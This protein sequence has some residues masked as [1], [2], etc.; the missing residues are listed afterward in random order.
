MVIEGIVDSLDGVADAL[1]PA[2][3]QNQKTGKFELQVKGYTTA[4]KVTE[5]RDNNVDLSK[6]IAKYETEMAEYRALGEDPKALTEEV[7]N[8]RKLGQQLENQE[9]VDKKGFEG[10]LAQ[11]VEQM[12]QD[13]EGKVAAL[14]S[15]LETLKGERDSAVAENKRIV[16]SGDITRAALAEGVLPE[17]IPDLLLRADHSGWTRNEKGDV[18]L[19][20]KKSN[21]IVYGANGADPLTPEEWVIGLKQNARH[22]FNR[23]SGAGGLGSDH[24][25]GAPNPWAKDTWDDTAQALAYRADPVRAEAM[26][27]AAGS[28]VGAL[29]P[30]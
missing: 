8:L 20:D 6:R 13:F 30:A 21:S 28:Y 23:P 4:E 27:K 24:N 11:R 3:T 1:K 9:L 19:F 16:V 29:K 5:F 2:Y 7:T 22:F 15:N 10:A 26:A 12:K 18:V 14:K 25:A 17:A